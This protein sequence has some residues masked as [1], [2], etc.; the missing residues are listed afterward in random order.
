MDRD[1]LQARVK[2][3]ALRVIKLVEA[4][5]SNTAGREIGRQV[6]RSATSASANYRAA[7][8]ARSPKEFLAKIC[9]V[10]E[11]TDESAH[12]LELIVEAE[13]LSA[14][15]VT[16]LLQEATELMR[17]FAATRATARRRHR[18]ITK[19][20]NHQIKEPA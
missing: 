6:L 4:L 10:V 14:Q 17:I 7:R 2:R 9:I 16:P 11:E 18:Q 13:L 1:E 20:P 3:F 5:P 8:R 12:W 15:K 19:S